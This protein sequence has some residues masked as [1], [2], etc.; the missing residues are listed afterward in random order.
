[1]NKNYINGRIT[2]WLLLLKGFDLRILD[3]PGKHNV[4]VNFLSILTN[5]T[6]NNAIDDN[7]PN[8]NIF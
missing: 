1:M 2:R 3:K 5:I 7:F 6:N 8:G 4:V